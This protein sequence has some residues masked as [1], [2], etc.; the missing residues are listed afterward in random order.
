MKLGFLEKDIN[1]AFKNSCTTFD[2]AIDW[3]CLNV[4]ENNLP[5]QFAAKGKQLDVVHLGTN[6]IFKSKQ[7]SIG[8]FEGTLQEEFLF[9]YGFKIE[10]IKKY[11]KQSNNDHIQ[12]LLALYN[13]KI[14][15]LQIEVE[16]PED[17][18]EIDKEDEDFFRGEI[19]DPEILDNV[20]EIWNTSKKKD[21]EIK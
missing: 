14:S 4:D 13:D 5:K 8:S 20:L 11:L 2:D 15:G 1:S 17:D 16:N 21:E 9:K 19:R 10:D 7:T 3:L 12:A 18:N 6:N